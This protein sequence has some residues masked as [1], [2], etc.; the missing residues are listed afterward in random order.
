[1]Y[2]IR[3][4]ISYMWSFFVRLKKRVK[5]AQFTFDQVLDL[6]I[7]NGEKYVL[8]DPFSRRPHPSQVFYSHRV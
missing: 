5:R 6:V 2:D 8:A 7:G 4:L 1:M 3:P